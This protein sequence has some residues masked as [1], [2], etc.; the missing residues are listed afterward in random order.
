[1]ENNFNGFNPK[2]K[3]KSY[4][5]ESNKVSEKFKT[6]LKGMGLEIGFGGYAINK[7]S[8][9]MDLPQA[10]AYT[11][12]DIQH[13][14]GDC[15]NLYWFQNNVLD[16]IVSSH[17]L[18]DFLNTES[19]LQEWQRIVKINGYIALYLPNQI[20]YV[21]SCEKRGSLPNVAHKINNFSLEYLIDITNKMGNLKLVHST[22][23]INEYSF[24]AVFKKIK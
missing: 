15:R 11:G 21:K 10:Y 24:E 5:P 18:E 4:Q 12:N 6:Y 3:D 13:L 22:G 1:M 20:A 16:Y 17:T 8:I 7:N 19:I 23:I 9:N 14:A 2:H